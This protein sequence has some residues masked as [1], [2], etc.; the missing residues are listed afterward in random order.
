M[1]IALPIND[2]ETLASFGHAPNVAL[3]TVSSGEI[4]DWQ[5]HKT[6]WDVLH[7]MGDHGQHHARMVR[8]LAGHGVQHVVFDRM[9][10]PMQLV[11]AK[12]GIGL[13]Q[14]ESTQAREAAR[15]AASTLG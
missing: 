1:L 9:G 11:V 3:A 5:V 6:E 4:T 15:L 8:F 10:Q 13:H 7:D 12:M 14:A 2:D